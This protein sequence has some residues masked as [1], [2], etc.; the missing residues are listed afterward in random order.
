MSNE[1]QPVLPLLDPAAAPCSIHA[2]VC[3]A[4]DGSV[5]EVEL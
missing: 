4:N 2:L 5:Q 1:I 3:P